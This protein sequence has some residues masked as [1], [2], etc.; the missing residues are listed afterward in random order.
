MNVESSNLD[1]KVHLLASFDPGGFRMRVHHLGVAVEN[2]ELAVRTYCKTLGMRILSGPI[3]DPLQRVR[4]CFLGT[5]LPGDAVVE[6]IS[7]LG[8]QSPIDKYL[9]KEIGAYHLCYEVDDL[10]AALIHMRSE[11]CLLVSGPVP[12]TAFDGRQ[13]AWLYLPTRHLVELVEMPKQKG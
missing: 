6:L 11:G 5:T 12:A 4:V 1:P 10:H 3:D 2:M 13:I 8:D 7:S 9:R